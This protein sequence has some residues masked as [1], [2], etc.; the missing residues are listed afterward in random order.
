MKVLSNVRTVYFELEAHDQHI[1]TFSFTFNGKTA[2][3]LTVMSQWFNSCET[4]HGPTCGY[5]K[6]VVS[7]PQTPQPEPEPE[8][9][10]Q[11]AAGCCSD[12]NVSAADVRHVS[13]LCPAANTHPDPLT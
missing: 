4:S 13:M 8:P 10:P 5:L 11:R 7:Q 12:W 6:T 2:D 3:W 1:P 9:V